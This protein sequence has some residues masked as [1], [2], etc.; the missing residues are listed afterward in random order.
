MSKTHAKL[1]LNP[2]HYPLTYLDTCWRIDGAYLY[3][4]SNNFIAAITH[5]YRLNLSGNLKATKTLP[6]S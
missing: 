6:N 5:L 4:A 2:S 3:R 1:S